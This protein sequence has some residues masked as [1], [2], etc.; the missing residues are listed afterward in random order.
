VNIYVVVEGEVG[1]R[2]V[3]KHWIPLVNPLLSYVEHIDLID[4][5]NF[6]ILVGG[7]YP[8]YFDV[9]ESA[10]GDVNSCLT[11]DRLVIAVDSE[12]LTYDEKCQEMHDFLSSRD[13]VAEIHLVVQHFCLETWALGNRVIIKR[14]PQNR[15][16]R[17]YKR[18]YNV[19]ERDPEQLPGYSP[20]E[21]NRAQFAEKYLRRAL[22][23]KY[24]NLTYSKNNPRA[25]LHHLYF[26]RVAQRFH[27]TGHIASFRAFLTA[28]V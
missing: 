25:L 14:N 28:F 15:K 12:N 1:E 18:L 24:R 27:E 4:Y 8:R 9:I 21:L 5:N 23:E 26:E 16:L 3:Y 13:C 7:G 20:E 17:E 19:R 10:I 22:N 11:V 6:A 2:K